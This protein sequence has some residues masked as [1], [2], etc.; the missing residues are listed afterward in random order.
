MTAIDFYTQE[1][2]SPGRDELVSLRAAR[3]R[4]RATADA[5][6]TE[7]LDKL[8]WVPPATGFLPHCRVGT[9]S[10]P[11]PDLGRSRARAPGTAACSQPA[12]RRRPSSRF[13]RMA[14]IVGTTIRRSRRA[15]PLPLLP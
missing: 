13:E 8:L 4:A 2:S 3:Q 11:N 5:A 7:A 6:S 15:Q 1:R 9:A 10:P 12:R 14:E